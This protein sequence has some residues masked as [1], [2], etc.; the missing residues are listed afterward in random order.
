MSWR[1]RGWRQRASAD[2][3]VESVSAST[4]DS[5]SENALRRHESW[6]HGPAESE[7]C[8]HEIFSFLR[9]QPRGNIGRLCSVAATCFCRKKQS[10]IVCDSASHNPLMNH[11]F[12][13]RILANP[14]PPPPCKSETAQRP[15]PPCR[16]VTCRSASRLAYPRPRRPCYLPGS[17][18]F[19]NN[20]G[21]DPGPVMPQMPQLR[22][23]AKAWV[24][25]ESIV[26]ALLR[27]RIVNVVRALRKQA[28]EWNSR[29]RKTKT[30]PSQSGTK[31][32]SSV[33]RALLHSRNV[34]RRT[35]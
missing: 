31:P 1:E 5:D 18:C 27:L 29:H 14:R 20:P 10:S 30:Q 28:Q 3:Y 34:A 15:L 35:Q 13:T 7:Y 2:S 32:L 8:R 25:P 33:K 9:N 4:I 24:V 21:R 17:S 11:T 19:S 26:T 12:L 16:F 6:R 23:K 22:P